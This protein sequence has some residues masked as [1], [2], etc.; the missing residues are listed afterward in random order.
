[1]KRLGPLRQ[2]HRLFRGLIRTT[3]AFMGIVAQSFVCLVEG[4]IDGRVSLWTHADVVFR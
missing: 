1:V 4:Y 2:L 3:I